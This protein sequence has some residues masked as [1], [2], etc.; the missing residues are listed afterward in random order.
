MKFIEKE[1]DIIVRIPRKA[2][3]KHV[4]ILL[5]EIQYKKIAMKSKATQKDIDEIVAI[6]QKERKKTMKPLIDRLLKITK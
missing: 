4:Q 1:D 2:Y 3:D 5:D 6:V